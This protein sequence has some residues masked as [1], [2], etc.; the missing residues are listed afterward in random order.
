MG[1]TCVRCAGQFK[2][3]LAAPGSVLV[4]YVFL[5]PGQWGRLKGLSVLASAAQ[6][7]RAMGI[8]VVCVCEC[9]CGGWCG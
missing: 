6:N 3:S 1:H 8:K 7:L 5:E 2:L 9:V 4:N